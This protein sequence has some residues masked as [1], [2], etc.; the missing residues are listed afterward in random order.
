[1]GTEKPEKPFMKKL[2]T[3]VDSLFNKVS[4][5]WWGIGGSAVMVICSAIAA[6]FYRGPTDEHYSFFSYFI[7]ELGEIAQSEAH[8]LFNGGLIVGG[9]MLGVFVLGVGF[10]IKH[11]LGYIS[12]AFGL[13]SAVFVALV[14]IFPM[15]YMD[16]HAFVAMTFFFYGMVTV[17]FFS[18]TFLIDKKRIIPPWFSLLGVVVILCFALFLY[19]PY[20]PVMPDSD[21]E[22]SLDPG[23]FQRPDFWLMPFFEW[24]VF[25]SVLGWM[26]A[27]AL[28]LK[29]QGVIS[30]NR[31]KN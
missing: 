21:G 4:L 12:M 5:P 13:F 23:V 11:W 14:G 16:A 7:S 18:I 22:F 2:D 6:I 26:T 30:P 27:L 20:E 28:Y 15:D 31:I 24:L 9:A 1:M 3:F 29:S 10:H 25:F 8:W 19:Y 17:I